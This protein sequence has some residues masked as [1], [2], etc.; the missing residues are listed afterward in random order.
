MLL[1]SNDFLYENFFARLRHLSPSIAS[2]ALFARTI[3]FAAKVAKYLHHSTDVPQEMRAEVSGRSQ[4]RAGKLPRWGKTARPQA[5]AY[6]QLTSL[7]RAGGN[8]GLAPKAA[9]CMI[10]DDADGLH[11]GIYD[12]R[13]D[14][15]ET[16]PLHLLR[17]RFRERG[18]GDPFA[19]G[20]LDCLAVSE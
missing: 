10:V 15:L 9:N 7:Q 2:V 8:V 3:R 4:R 13:A 14:K 17:N 6:D 12:R 1:I 11:P 5:A 20:V 18:F 19:T 16:S